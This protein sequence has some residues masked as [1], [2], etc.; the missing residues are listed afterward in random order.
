ME[1]KSQYNLNRFIQI[2]QI[3]FSRALS[4]IKSGRKQSHWMWY[5][6]PQLKALGR[7][8]TS[9]YYGISGL[10]E[11]KAYMSEPYLRNNLIT[12]SRALLSLDESDPRMIM[13]IPDDIKLR[14]C[15][16]LFEMAAPDVSEFKLVLEKFYSGS[17]DNLTIRLLRLSEKE[18]TSDESK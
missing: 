15:M 5:I 10:D 1:K 2:Q 4:E 11:A 7:S 18:D 8:S 17:R 6:F 3:N 9:L 14:S 12:I 13:G 16:T